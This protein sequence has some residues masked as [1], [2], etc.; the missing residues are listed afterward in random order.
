MFW[1]VLIIQ[2]KFISL[3]NE[4]IVWVVNVNVKKYK[5]ND[6]RNHI[7]ITKFS[8]ICLEE[9]IKKAESENMRTIKILENTLHS[10]SD[11]DN[12][13]PFL[14]RFLVVYSYFVIYLTV[15]GW[16]LHAL[17]VPWVCCPFLSFFSTNV[18]SATHHWSATKSDKKG[19]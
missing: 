15:N 12:L 14:F 19:T 10:N 4:S 16:V 1:L 5:M 6:Q 18:L 7:Y 17:G 2:Q 11:V 9:K 3:N 8:K 13:F